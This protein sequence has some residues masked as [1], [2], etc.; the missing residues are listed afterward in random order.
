MCGIAYL[1]SE[2]FSNDARG[3]RKATTTRREIFTLEKSITRAEWSTAGQMGLNA[4]A[5]LLTPKC[6][7][8]G[9]EL[10]EYNGEMYR[11]YRT[12]ETNE[13]I[14]LYLEKKGGVR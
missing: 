1:I 9:E 3:V 11:I 7:Y 8:A 10:I 13:N 14:E 12:F 4:A 2:T 6:N 5:C